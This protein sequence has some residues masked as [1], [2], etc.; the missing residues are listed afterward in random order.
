MS[1]MTIEC[2][3]V[4][5]FIH[6]LANVPQIA[7]QPFRCYCGVIPALPFRWCA[8]GEGGCA[9]PGLANLPHLQGFAL[10]VQ[11]GARRLAD[12]SHTINELHGEKACLGRF[13]SAEFHQQYS[14]TLGKKFQIWRS[15]PLESLDNT[16]FKSFESDRMKLQ[17][18]W[19]MVGC[20]E[21]IA[22]P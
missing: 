13:I 10:R 17:Y 6:Q 15:F 3:P 20:E 19:N 14:A 5:V 2:P 11:P 8:G 21:R 7:S 12:I 9:R 16:S 4:F 18:R 22:I 1:K